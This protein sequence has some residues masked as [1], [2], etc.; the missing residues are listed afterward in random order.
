VPDPQ[1][2]NTFLRSKL[3]WGQPSREPHA[4]LLD[5]YRSLIALR[6]SRPELTDPRLDQVRAEFS[7]NDRWL[8]VRRGAL[9][10]VV[11]L[12]DREAAVPLSACDLNGPGSAV[13][14]LASREGISVTGDA[15]R[16][17]SATFGVMES[18]T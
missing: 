7:E 3:D 6:R 10:I 14:L 16:I 9:R 2:P 11:N 18:V 4:S 1:D 13:T 12:G 15:L 8:V 17:P 5:W